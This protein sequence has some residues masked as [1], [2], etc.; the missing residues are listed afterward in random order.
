MKELHNKLKE[1]KLFIFDFDG[2]LYNANECFYKILTKGLA[3]QNINMTIDQFVTL[4]K[5]CDNFSEYTTYINNMYNTSFKASE[6]YFKYLLLAE[7]IFTE[8]KCYD[9]VK[10]LMTIYSDKRFI[11]LSNQNEKII[12][13][14]LKNW[15]IEQCFEQ[16][17]SCFQQNSLKHNVYSNVESYFNVSPNDCVMFEDTQ[18]Y[19]DTGAKVGITG[20][21]IQNH[22]NKGK[23]HGDY[24]I[25]TI[26][27]LEKDICNLEK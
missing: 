3:E 10:E 20:I 22:F 9:Y 26:D 25:N 18:Y 2:T 6:F 15:N 11:I 19:L 16:I 1:K 7:E 17:I 8:T 27:E 23:I 12:R 24:L 4:K 5:N 21:A 13:T 14:C